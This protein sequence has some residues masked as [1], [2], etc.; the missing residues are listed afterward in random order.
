MEFGS[1][2][3]TLADLAEGASVH[4]QRQDPGSLAAHSVDVDGDTPLQLIESIKPDVLVKGEDYNKSQVV[5]ADH[6]ISLILPENEP[7]AGV[8]RKLGMTVWKQAPHGYVQWL[9]D[10]WRVD[11]RQS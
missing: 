8:A 9:H 5:G 11:L 1:H 7:S 6:V 4:V 3:V 2:R 10:V